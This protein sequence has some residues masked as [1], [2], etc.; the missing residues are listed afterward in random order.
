MSQT[1]MIQALRD[2]AFVAG[3]QEQMEAILS[4]SATDGKFRQQ[5][6]TSPREALSEHFGR[7][8]PETVNIVFIENRA[9]ATIVLPDF[10]DLQ[11]ELSEADLEAVAGGEPI[12]SCII[13]GG[14]LYAIGK[15]IFT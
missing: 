5:L 13:I 2:P 7:E 4:R 12:S 6:L 14:C 15:L 8:I 3:A 1:E 9:D 11:A 10:V